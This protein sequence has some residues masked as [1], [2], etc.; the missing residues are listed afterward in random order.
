[1]PAINSAITGRDA[2]APAGDD[3]FHCLAQGGRLQIRQVPKRALHFG[4]LSF[5][6]RLCALHGLFG[7]GQVAVLAP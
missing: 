5:D 3:L 1:M 6:Q 2:F 4:Q 7:G